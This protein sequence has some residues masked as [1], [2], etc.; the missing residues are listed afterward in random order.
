MKKFSGEGLREH[1]LDPV[2]E[3]Q[4]KFTLKKKEEQEGCG[5]YYR[6]SLD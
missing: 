1:G 2:R 3:E 5:L 4:K 6:L